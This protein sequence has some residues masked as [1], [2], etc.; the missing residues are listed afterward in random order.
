MWHSLF[1]Q[2]IILKE[3]ILDV[4][5][6]QPSISNIVSSSLPPHYD[7]EYMELYA[8]TKYLL[9]HKY[10]GNPCSRISPLLVY[11]QRILIIFPNCFSA[12]ALNSFRYSNT[13]DFFLR[14]KHPHVH[15]P[16]INKSKHI[17]GFVNGRVR[18]TPH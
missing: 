17:F 4:T 6:N 18:E 11:V 12:C 2:P 16:I 10:V 14:K 15:Q 8:A 1:L 13:S 7:V 3:E 9:H 5:F